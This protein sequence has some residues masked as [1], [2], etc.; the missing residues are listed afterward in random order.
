MKEYHRDFVGSTLFEG[1][2]VIVVTIS[3]AFAGVCRIV[4]RYRRRSYRSSL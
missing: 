2:E 3:G 1:V 4:L